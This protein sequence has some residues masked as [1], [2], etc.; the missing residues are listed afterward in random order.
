MAK[1]LFSKQSDLYA[2]Y[3]PTYPKELYDHILSFVKEKNIAWDCATGN[4]QAAVVLAD[5]FKKV[6]ATDISAAQ[7]EK[8]TLKDNIEYLVCPAE[9]TPFEE[10]TFD[11]VTVAQA[12]NWIK[13]GEF[14]NE[15]TRVCKPGAVIAIW[16]Y[17]RNKI[18]DKNI[19]DAVYSFYENVTKTYWDY[20][21]K[22]VEELYETV[23]FDYELLPVK[24]F[25]TTLNWQRED[26]IGYIS[27]WSAIQKY[28]KVNGHSPIPIIEEEINKLWPEGEVKKVSFPIYLKL[29]RV[30]K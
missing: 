13:W 26:M 17:N 24:Q 27:S 16:T 4:G 19:D 12:Y 21:R 22:Y 8:A 15:V 5:H 20:E 29:G 25:E 18:G 30:V 2:R 11:L 6:I 23:E 1:D 14:K 28:I 3:R 10:N 9:L 7:I